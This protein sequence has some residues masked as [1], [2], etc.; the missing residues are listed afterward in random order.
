MDRVDKEKIKVLSG[1]WR[2]KQL[3]YRQAAGTHFDMKHNEQY[4]TNRA[5]ADII[6]QVITDLNELMN[7]PD[8]V[9]KGEVVPYAMSPGTP[10]V[11]DDH[12]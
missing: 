9:K 8:T 10:A 4:L 1:K 5:R 6:D 3:E 12:A 2:T 7:P 11:E